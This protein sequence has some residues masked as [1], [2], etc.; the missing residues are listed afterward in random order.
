[1]V[2]ERQTGITGNDGP[3]VLGALSEGKTAAACPPFKI[4]CD[5]DCPFPAFL[6]ATRKQ[7]LCDRIL[8]AI[9]LA[10]RAAARLETKP[11]SP[12]T[13]ALFRQVFGQ[14]PTDP[15]E[16]PGQPSRTM[17]AGLMVV[18][19]LRGVARELQTRDT[20]YR[21]VSANRCLI[22]SGGSGP[23]CA[24]LTG[25]GFFSEVPPS[26]SGTAANTCHPTESIVVDAV[27][28]ALLCKN[29]VWLVS[30]ILADEEGMAG[31]YDPPRDVA[32]MLWF[33]VRM[34]SA[35]PKRSKKKQRQLL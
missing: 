9:N 5:V 35:R 16:L 1:M 26:P 34:V 3:G 27:A 28:M 21:C 6:C 25:I 15:W 30:D 18:Q 2:S 10:K 24:S 7:D 19:R 17:P 31:R 13:L 14:A 22:R 29:E 12:G 23:S 33:D 32:P 11:L 4:T 8:G 20:I